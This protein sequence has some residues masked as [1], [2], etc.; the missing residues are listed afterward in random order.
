MRRYGGSAGVAAESSVVFEL[1]F[2]GEEK[3]VIG[4]PVL[5]CIF[6]PVVIFCALHFE[7]A[8]DA[9][10]ARVGFVSDDLGVFEAGVTGLEFL[11][12]DVLVGV[13]HLS[14]YRYDITISSR[15]FILT[16]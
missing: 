2:V 6:F 1:G 12:S 14:T 7:G 4:G 3:E 11:L 8:L 5:C 13:A 15:S 10:A 9:A 16:Q